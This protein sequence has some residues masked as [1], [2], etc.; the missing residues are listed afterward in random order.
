MGEVSLFL[1]RPST[2]WMRLTHIM[3]GNLLDPKS[4]SLSVNVLQ[5]NTFGETEKAM[6]D[7]LS[8]NYGPA[9]LTNK[10]SHHII[11]CEV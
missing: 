10:I 6:L 1:L 11:C 7:Q 4:T 8:G 9:K 2:D 5:K 3:E